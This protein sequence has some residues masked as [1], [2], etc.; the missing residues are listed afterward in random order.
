MAV[1]G[2]QIGEV[3]LR[4]HGLGENH[5]LALP[6]LCDNGVEDAGQRL[7]EFVALAVV[8]NRKG[9][10]SVFFKLGEFGLELFRSIGGSACASPFSA[11]SN[12]SASSSTTS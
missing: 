1:G 6:A 10:L 12:S 8:A 2:E 4:A 3:A 11:S 9:E 5:C 7:D